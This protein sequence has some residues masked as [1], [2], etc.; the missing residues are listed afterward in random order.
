MC[1]VSLVVEIGFYPGLVQLTA[2]VVT[3]G[4]VENLSLADDLMIFMPPTSIT[5]GQPISI[6]QFLS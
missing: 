5:L 2:L 3:Y 6:G 1:I 4:V